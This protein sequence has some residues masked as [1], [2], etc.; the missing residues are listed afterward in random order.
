MAL[1]KIMRVLQ[2]DYGQYRRYGKTRVSW[3]IKLFRGLIQNHHH[4]HFFSDRDTAA[5]EAPL[6]WRDLGI[7]KANK[8]LIQTAIDQAPDLLILGHC[9]MIKN[10][11]IKAIRA[12]LPN[13]VVIHCNNDPLFVPENLQHIQHREEVVD[14][15]Y[16]S[17]G[18]PDLEKHINTKRV[19]LRYM[20]NPVDVS[21]ERFNTALLRS[22]ELENDVI[23]CSNTD[24]Y[25]TRMADI[26]WIKD[27]T[28]SF[29]RW[30]TPGGFGSPPL[31]GTDYDQLLS[32][33]KMGINSNRQEGYFW[34]SSARIAQM[35]GNGILC[36][37]HDSGALQSLYPEETLVYFS[38]REDL[39]KQLRAFHE[40]DA[41]RRH[42]AGRTHQIM[43]REFSSRLNAQYILETALGL[44]LSHDYLWLKNL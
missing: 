3:P 27:Q 17:T 40:D 29:L 19:A 16:V 10:E 33:T 41:M 6:G 25:T 13:L 18:V 20:C 23:F 8:L 39:A 11:T 42:Y 43:H 35:G 44:P 4:V 5:F 15:M 30:K 31:W 32:R 22:E 7:G 37:T 9:T 14:A 2:V 1:E 36:L 12:S 26:A 38:Q 24:K 28:S 21:I 34:Y